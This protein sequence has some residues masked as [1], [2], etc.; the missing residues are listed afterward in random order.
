MRQ[1]ALV[2]LFAG[3]LFCSRLVRVTNSAWRR[4][5]RATRLWT[6]Q[7]PTSHPPEDQLPEQ[8]SA[9]DGAALLGGDGVELPFSI[10]AAEYSGALDRIVIV[11]TE[12]KRLIVLDPES[13][14]YNTLTLPLLIDRMDG[15]LALQPRR[16]ISTYARPQ[17]LSAGC[18][19]VF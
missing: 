12:P 1:H 3:R 10:V 2:C 5:T 4:G 15:S 18:A 19:P 9:H 7:R 17:S 6:A 8:G 11:T 14:E 13:L 16:H